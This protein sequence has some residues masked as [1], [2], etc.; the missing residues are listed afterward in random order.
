MKPFGPAFAHEAALASPSVTMEAA[1]ARTRIRALAIVL[2]ALL[3]VLGGRS[4][5]L[6][7][8][9]DPN[10][11][12]AR[13]AAQTQLARA[14]LTDRNG[15][16]LATTVRAFTLTATP[17][18]V[19]NPPETAAALARVFPELD[20]A[21]TE[22]RLADRDRTLVYLRRG[23]TPS[24]RAQVMELGLAGIGFEAE[25]R[26]V[27]PNGSLAGH[28]LGYTNRD[29]EPLAGVER[30]LNERIRAAGDEAVRL[31]LDVRIQYAAEVELA[32][33]AET[34]RATGGAVVVLDGR[35]GE[36]LALASWP[37][38]DPN[39][40]GAATRESSRNRASGERYEMGSTVKAF[41][42]AM[43]LDLGLSNTSERFDLQRA[44]TV[45][46][47]AIVDHDRAPVSSGLREILTHSSNKG[48]AM[49]ALRVGAQRQ[50]SYLARLGLL[51][52]SPLQLQENAA[53]IAPRTQS[54]LDVATLGYGYGLAVSPAALAGAYTVFANNGQ[55]VAPTFAVHREGDTI[56]RDPVFSPEATRATLEMLRATVQTGT[57][58]EADVPGL[59]IA[60]KTGTA[61]KLG[62]GA[63]YDQDRMFSSF[64]AIFPA[65]DPRYVIVLALDEPARTAATGGHATGGA[66][67]ARPVGRIAQRIAPMLGLRVQPVNAGR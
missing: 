5:Q 62:E 12:R 58:R 40:A 51:E 24:Q 43:A 18:R 17:A 36:T 11:A 15:V 56:R 8:A 44:Y 23:L 31:S 10:A 25:D 39:N 4:V 30:G 64:A 65:F 20:R 59:A 55:R 6:A 32:R 28:A 47:R 2:I 46:G 41:T 38:L 57:G 9:G 50:R 45:D 35:T 7:F 26:R 34:S 22:R 54:R 66:V 33:A 19:W 61:E 67:A 3:A 21:V 13:P 1:P 16:L 60:G 48:A 37:A 49:I 29:L 14:D 53:P 42:V 27:Y 63:G 52:A